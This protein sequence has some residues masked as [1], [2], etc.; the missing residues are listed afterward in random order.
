MGLGV[1]AVAHS[2]GM[3]GGGLYRHA[4]SFAVGLEGAL[5][6]CEGGVVEVD[7]WGLPLPL[8]GQRA[9]GWAWGLGWGPPRDGA[10]VPRPAN[11]GGHLG[12]KPRDREGPCA[13]TGGSGAPS[14]AGPA[15]PSPPLL[16]TCWSAAHPWAVRRLRG[17]CPPPR[18]DRSNWLVARRTVAG[19]AAPDPRPHA[20]APE[21]KGWSC[22]H[23]HAHTPSRHKVH[24]LLV[25]GG[26]EGGWD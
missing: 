15:P 10:E 20:G 9:G 23:T 7:G 21:A 12:N 2:A 22:V 25:P 4:F 24:D 14:L 26:P 8:L 3:G 18:A 13:D 16:L 1:G 5:A 6:L 11:A 19:R 17:S